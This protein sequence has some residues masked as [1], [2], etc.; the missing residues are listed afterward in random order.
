MKR[1]QGF[2]LIELLVVIAI[3]AI[4]IGIILPAVQK[5]R[6]AAARTQCSNNLKQLGLAAM[7][8]HEVNQRLPSG[9]NLPVWDFT[10]KV[11]IPSAPTGWNGGTNN[12]SASTTPLYSSP[13]FND[14]TPYEIGNVGNP[15]AGPFWIPLFTA[16]LPY[17]EQNAIYSQLNLSTNQ[18]GN[19]NGPTSPGATVIKSY[20]CPSD[21]IASDVSTFVSNGTTFYFGMNSYGGNGGTR[22]WSY[23]FSTAYDPVTKLSPDNVSADGMFY[24]NSAVR[25]GDITDG[26]SNT[27]FFGERLHYDPNWQVSSSPLSRFGGWAWANDN[28]PADYLLS[29]PQPINYLSPVVITSTSTSKSNPNVQQAHD[30]LCAFGSAHP[31]GANFVFADGSVHFLTLTSNGQLSLLQALSTRAGNEVASVP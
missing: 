31:G 26:T 2:T 8:S 5:V 3:I 21:P 27:L 6:E 30:R 20:I 29:T 16:L 10:N 9:I 4:L 22:S 11:W 18:Y 28:A 17:M 14:D 12:P 13:V 25:I 23:S 15:P 19:C 1:R 7:N 24:I